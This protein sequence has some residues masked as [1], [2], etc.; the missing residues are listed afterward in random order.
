MEETLEYWQNVLTQ[1]QNHLSIMDSKNIQDDLSR[2][3]CKL[4]I[5]EALTQIEL[6]S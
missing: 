1:H 5:A 6:L 2:N 4:A 3:N